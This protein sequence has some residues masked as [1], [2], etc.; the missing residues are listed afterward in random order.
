M[1][2]PAGVKRDFEALE[3]ATCG[4]HRPTGK[5]DHRLEAAPLTGVSAD[6]QPWADSFSGGGRETLKKAGRAGRK[7]ELTEADRER[8]EDL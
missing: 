2:H 1:G 7:P 8:L 3:K 6:G 5:D 4:S